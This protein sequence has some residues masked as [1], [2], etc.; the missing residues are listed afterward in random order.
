MERRRARR[1]SVVSRKVE[2]LVTLICKELLKRTE[3]R[4]RTFD[5]LIMMEDSEQTFSKQRNHKLIYSS[6]QDTE[7]WISSAATVP[8]KAETPGTASTPNFDYKNAQDCSAQKS[9]KVMW[10]GPSFET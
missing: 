1:M 8:T 4:T 5:C 3:E 9:G 6:G 2:D 10:Q 7:N